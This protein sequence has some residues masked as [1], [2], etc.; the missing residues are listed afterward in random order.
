MQPYNPASTSTRRAPGGEC[1]DRRLDVQVAAGFAG[2][3]IRDEL[4]HVID[5]R[6]DARFLATATSCASTALTAIRCSQVPKPLRPSNRG[7]ARQPV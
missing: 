3:G 1:G 5:G 7:S 6:V 4:E 2:G